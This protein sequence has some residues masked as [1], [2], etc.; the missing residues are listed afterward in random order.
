[1]ASA[2]DMQAAQKTYDG[3]ITLLKYAVPVIAVIGLLV[4]V[5]NSS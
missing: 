3:F 5:A 2:N 1:M 4:V